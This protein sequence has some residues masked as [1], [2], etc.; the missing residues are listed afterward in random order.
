M[1]HKSK[2]E[3]ECYAVETITHMDMSYKVAKGSTSDDSVI[4]FQKYRK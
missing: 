3:F 4:A 2:H 1:F